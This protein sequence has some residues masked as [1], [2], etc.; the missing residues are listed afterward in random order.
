MP[1]SFLPSL[2]PLYID[3]AMKYEE[4]HKLYGQVNYRSITNVAYL[5]VDVI[6]H[7]AIGFHSWILT[8]CK[9]A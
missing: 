2:L 9:P 8:I 5:S 3:K 6:L 1:L 4:V 7:A